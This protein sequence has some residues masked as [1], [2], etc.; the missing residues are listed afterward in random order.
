MFWSS[1]APFY[2]YNTRSTTDS[3]GEATHPSPPHPPPTHPLTSRL[4]IS[5]VYL[6]DK[7]VQ[8]CSRWYQGARDSPYP[9][10]HTFEKFSQC[11]LSDKSNVGLTDDGSF[12]SFLPNIV[13]H[14]LRLSPPG[15]P[16]CDKLLSPPGESWCHK[17][18]SPP[19]DPW[20]DKPLSPPGDLWCDKPLSSP[21]DPWCDKPL[22][23]PGDLWC[24]KP[25]SP[26]GDPV[27]DKHLSP[28]VETWCD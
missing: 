16:W 8:F 12:S 1:S 13:E 21:G 11:C 19:G 3:S 24:D 22:S 6:V 7:T 27:C 14:F 18:L 4:S 17:P 15:N 2:T 20:C 26:P 23:P 28:P 10:H 5:W 25:L 9:F